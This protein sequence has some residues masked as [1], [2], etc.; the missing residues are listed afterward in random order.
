[1]LEQGVRHSHLISLA[2]YTKDGNRL[3]YRDRL[4]LPAHEP[5]NLAIIL[6]NH[7]AP[8]T[9]HPGRSKTHELIRRRYHWPSM[10]KEIARYVANCYVCQQSR[11]PRHAPFGIP[12]PLPIPYR[13]WQD[14]LMDF[15]TGLPW[16]NANDALW[17]VVD[18]LTKM[19]HLVPCRTTMDATS[20]ADIFL[21]NIW[22]HHGVPL[23][24]I[25][26]RGPQFA[27][28]FWGTI[29]HRLKIDRRLSTTVHPETDG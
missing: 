23:T 12:Q 1:M 7:D 11:T 2:E 28:E 17:V 22:K 4:Y 24:I 13:P 3:R 18:R 29:C 6:E 21:D 8:A 25:S 9:C 27:A 19:R 15:V 10:R 20:L 14:I 16:S 26:D 5:L